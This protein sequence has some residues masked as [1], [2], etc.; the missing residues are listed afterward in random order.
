[1]AVILAVGDDAHSRWVQALIVSCRRQ[2]SL[3]ICA[4]V[5][6][7]GGVLVI[8]KADQYQR[9]THFGHQKTAT[10]LQITVTMTPDMIRIVSNG[11]AHGPRQP[12]LHITSAPLRPT[13]QPIW[14]SEDVLS[15]GQ[16][17]ALLR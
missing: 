9:K 13:I 7:V 10:D 12:G 3:G 11:P 15:P 17:P 8:S 4:E 16:L 6:I 2:R 1:M 5:L 14:L